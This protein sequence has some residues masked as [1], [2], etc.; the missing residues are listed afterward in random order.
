MIAQGN[1]DTYPPTLGRLGPG[2]VL[3]A[4]SKMGPMGLEDILFLLFPGIPGVL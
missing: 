2:F 1:R 4:V 3:G